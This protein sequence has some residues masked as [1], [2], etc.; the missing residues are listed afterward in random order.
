[1]SIVFEFLL[2]F[3]DTGLCGAIMTIL[4]SLVATHQNRHQAK[5]EMVSHLVIAV[6]HI[7]NLPQ[8]F[9]WV[10]MC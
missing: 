2:V 1:M 6:D 10:C 8:G 5:N 9:V 7:K 3:N 4:F